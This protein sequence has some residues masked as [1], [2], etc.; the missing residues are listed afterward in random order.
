MIGI[1]NYGIGNLASVYNAFNYL[2]H[3]VEIFDNQNSI[4]KYSHL[5][6]PGVGSFSAGMNMLCAGKFV[7]EIISFVDS[8]RPLL[9]ICLGMQMLLDS[10]DEN[11]FTSG[12]GLVRGRVVRFSSSN[13]LK[14]PHVGWNSL[15][16]ITKH[17]VMNSIKTSVDMYFSHSYYCQPDDINSVISCCDYGIRFAAVIAKDNIIGVQFHPEKSQPSGLKLLDNFAVWNGQ[18]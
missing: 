10:S 8:G 13:G 1:L 11:G 6:L 12:I 4:N 9:G 5:V 3:E 7:S 15:Q 17:P 18:C 14:V 2:G 16:S